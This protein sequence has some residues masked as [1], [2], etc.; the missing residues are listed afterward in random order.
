MRLPTYIG[1]G[2]RA[3]RVV[4][5]AEA[6]EPAAAE[7]AA[8][9]VGCV[10]ARGAQQC[11]TQGLACR[12][13]FACV[14]VCWF[15]VEGAGGVEAERR[16]KKKDGGRGNAHTVETT[17]QASIT[18]SDRSID[19]KLMPLHSPTRLGR[20]QVV[21]KEERVHQ[22]LRLQH[23]QPHGGGGSSSSSSRGRGGGGM[24]H[25]GVGVWGL[26]DRTHVPVR[27]GAARP[28]QGVL[29]SM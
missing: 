28:P 13:C 20:L 27:R 26:I 9:E 29:G 2:G 10:G 19:R 15:R 22:Q 23:R 18:R 16:I 25:G 11:L 6:E 21:D 12:G 3:R 1:V 17:Q 14:C 7:E 8:P 4:P 5:A 24:G